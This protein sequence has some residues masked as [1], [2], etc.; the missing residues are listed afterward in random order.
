MYQRR[1][2]S[3]SSIQDFTISEEMIK[4]AIEWFADSTFERLIALF[5]TNNNESL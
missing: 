5:L 3:E 1:N 2:P 4:S